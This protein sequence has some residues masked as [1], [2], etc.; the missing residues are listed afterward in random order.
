MHI[1]RH[2]YHASIAPKPEVLKA[3]PLWHLVIRCEGA[4]DVLV[5]KDAVSKEDA[6]AVA[7]LEITR[8]QRASQS[9]QKRT[10]S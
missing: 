7:L 3:E 1:V 9:G 6:A 10:A 2:P 5:R 8:L 4:P